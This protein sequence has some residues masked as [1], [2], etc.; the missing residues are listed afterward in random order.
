MHFIQQYL[1]FKAVIELLYPVCG[2]LRR[3]NYVG[4]FVKIVEYKGVKLYW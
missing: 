4:F 1:I 2:D 3:P